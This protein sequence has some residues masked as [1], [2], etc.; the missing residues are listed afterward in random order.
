MQ[1]GSSETRFYNESH[2]FFLET[3]VCQR[4]GLKCSDLSAD[5][6]TPPARILT[7]TAQNSHVLHFFFFLGGGGGVRKQDD[8]TREPPGPG[9]G[10]GPGWQATGPGQSSSKQTDKQAH[11]VHNPH[12]V[13]H[14]GGCAVSQYSLLIGQAFCLS[15]RNMATYLSPSVLC[16]RWAWHIEAPVLYSGEMFKPNW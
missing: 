12:I 8:K 3:F 1:T 13:S 11:T 14:M 10:P 2:V 4:F 5:P 7:R 15:A 16:S 9:P 6:L